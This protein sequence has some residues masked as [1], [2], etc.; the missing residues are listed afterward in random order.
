MNSVKDY[1]EKIHISLKSL[2]EQVYYTLDEQNYKPVVLYR[3]KEKP[4]LYSKIKRENI[5]DIFQVKDIYGLR[6]LVCTKKHIFSAL[7]SLKETLRLKVEHD[8]VTRPKV[9]ESLPGKSLKMLICT[10]EINDVVF[11]LQITTKRWDTQNE[12]LHAGYKS[13]Q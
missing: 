1:Q 12:K 2:A 11:E 3:L 6:V 8:Y 9:S 5:H 4:S 13:K 10:G 7:E